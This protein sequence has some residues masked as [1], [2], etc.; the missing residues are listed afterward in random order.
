VTMISP[1]RADRFLSRARRSPTE[2]Q[3]VHREAMRMRGVLYEILRA[4]ATGRRAKP[5]TLDTL[6]ELERTAL[7]NARL[8][9]EEDRWAWSWEQSSPRDLLWPIA[10]SATELLTSDEIGRLKLCSGC[11]WLFLDASKNDSRRWCTMTGCGNRA[12]ARRFAARHRSS[13]ES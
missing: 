3:K 5:R 12:K 8:R 4:S 2:A 1:T 13:R 10:H 6:R 7:R 11:R 9:W